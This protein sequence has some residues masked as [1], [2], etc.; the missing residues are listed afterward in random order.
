M[1]GK[2]LKN[3]TSRNPGL[4]VSKKAP[5]FARPDMPQTFYRTLH[6]FYRRGIRKIRSP[7]PRISKSERF[8]SLNWSWYV[9]LTRMLS[10]SRTAKACDPE[11]A[12]SSALWLFLTSSVTRLFAVK[13]SISAFLCKRRALFPPRQSEPP[14]KMLKL[15]T[16][17]TLLSS[18]R[19]L[20][21]ETSYL[22][23]QPASISTDGI[24]GAFARSESARAFGRGYRRPHIG[25]E[26]H[27]FFNFSLQLRIQGFEW[28][29]RFY[30]IHRLFAN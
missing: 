1:S 4:L 6:L 18:S 7:P 15:I 12:A 26:S 22:R 21:P 11:V 17:I 20:V 3:Q 28:N 8:P 30:K 25:A 16:A 10:R 14:E 29:N 13:T 19:P 9:F 27:G 2:L 23:L 5:G 24:K